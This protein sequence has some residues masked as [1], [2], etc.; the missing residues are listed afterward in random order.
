MD[1]GKSIEVR[2]CLDLV[3]WVFDLMENMIVFGEWGFL[4]NECLCQ[5]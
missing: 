5:P 1:I 4:G 2:K 3:E